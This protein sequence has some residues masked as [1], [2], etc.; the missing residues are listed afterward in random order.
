MPAFT[1]QA[2]IPPSSPYSLGAFILTWFCFLL[3]TLHL[4]QGDKVLFVPSENI[5]I[6]CMYLCLFK[7][8][9]H[10]TLHLDQTFVWYFT[11]SGKCTACFMDSVNSSLFHSTFVCH[12]LLASRLPQEC[13]LMSHTF[14][15]HKWSS[16]CSK[17]CYGEV[18]SDQQIYLFS[19][20]TV[21]YPLF[22]NKK[23]KMSA[24]YF[25]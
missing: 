25:S 10:S 3:L 21:K 17:F 8:I 2:P 11:S 22:V 19:L 4:D 16:F 23:D 7:N 20:L 15:Y 5:K 1:K 18:I 6:F 9:G 13:I 24:C 14:K 12:R